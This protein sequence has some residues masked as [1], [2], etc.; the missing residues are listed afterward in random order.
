M[1]IEFSG[2]D[3]SGKSTLMDHL[4]GFLNARGV[5]CIERQLRSTYKRILADIARNEGHGH[6]SSLYPVEEVE[7]AHAMEMLTTVMSTVVPL[8]Q[9]YQ[10]IVTDT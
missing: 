10:V 1:I 9:S 7:L 4:R 3:G 6:W 5:P 2:V 8:D